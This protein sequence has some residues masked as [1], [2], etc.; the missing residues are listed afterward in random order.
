MKK[1]V[2]FLAISS[3]CLAASSKG[4]AKQPTMDMFDFPFSSDLLDVFDGSKDFFG[5]GNQNVTQDP[6][7]SISVT[8]TDKNN[9]QKELFKYQ[10]P[11]SNNTRPISTEPVEIV[12]IKKLPKDNGEKKPK[13]KSFRPSGFYDK[14]KDKFKSNSLYNL[15]TLIDEVIEDNEKL[16]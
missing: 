6:F 2:A 1:T 3:L 11:K 15:G 14:I 13:K 7:V 12:P 9:E 5:S 10:T 8:G 4:R 16:E